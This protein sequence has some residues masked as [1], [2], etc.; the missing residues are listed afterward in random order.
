LA[1]AS[2][3]NVPPKRFS[4]RV[5]DTGMNG[6]GGHESEPTWETTVHGINSWKLTAEREWPGRV[7]IVTPPVIQ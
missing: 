3:I 4:K 2:I 7:A 6:W 1:D 5:P